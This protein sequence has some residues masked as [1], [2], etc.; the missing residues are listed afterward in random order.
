MN[1]PVEFHVLLWFSLLRHSVV[2]KVQ[3][4]MVCYNSF[5]CNSIHVIVCVWFIFSKIFVFI[6]FFPSAGLT[7][8]IYECS[9]PENVPHV[10]NEP[11]NV[12]LRVF[13]EIFMAGDTP[14]LDTVI[15]TLLSE[16]NHSPHLFGVFPE[17][18]LEEFI[19]VRL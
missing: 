9:L 10:D 8:Y 2:F 11:R 18:R 1:S 17:G 14:L 7:N 13:G 12:L 19:P 15:F 3:Y 16:R 4:N 6:V 5:S